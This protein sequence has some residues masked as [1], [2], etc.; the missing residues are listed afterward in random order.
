MEVSINGGTPSHHPHFQWDFPNKNHPAFFLVA[1][2][3]SWT[4]PCWW[5]WDDFLGRGSLTHPNAEGLGVVG[6]F[7]Y[8]M[9][10]TI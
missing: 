2:M 5:I 10:N 3:A 8:F 7:V 9:E 1:T 6:E 4:P